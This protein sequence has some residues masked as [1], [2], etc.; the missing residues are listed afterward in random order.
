MSKSV[1]KKWK[2][3]LLMFSGK[4]NPEW[5]ADEDL[6]D[7]I[8]KYCKEA[9]PWEQDFEIPVILGYNGIEFFNNEKKI[10]AF[11]GK[12]EIKSKTKSEFKTDLGRKLE[13]LILKNAP[14]PYKDLAW[15]Q[16]N[17]DFD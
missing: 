6:A 15:H 10:T 1:S 8:L 16:L 7:K 12:M 13:I 4:E 11:K 3:R 17:I 14:E 2:C 5:V 9:G